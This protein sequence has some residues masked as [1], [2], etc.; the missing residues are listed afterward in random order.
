MGKAAQCFAISS[1][2]SARWRL[3]RRLF[4]FSR[5]SFNAFVTASV[6][7]SPVRAARS[8]A[9][10]SVS[11]VRMFKDMFSF[12]AAILLYC[13]ISLHKQPF[14]QAVWSGVPRKLKN[15]VSHG[16]HGGHRGEIGVGHLPARVG[17]F[18]RYEAFSRSLTFHQPFRFGLRLSR[19]P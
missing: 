5:R 8:E 13:Y 9:S 19:Y 1:S 7:V 15:G 16:G 11:R 4:I 6:F 14:L 3:L 12:H 18:A 2:L 17:Q 10:F